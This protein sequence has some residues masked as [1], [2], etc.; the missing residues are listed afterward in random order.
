VSASAPASGTYAPAAPQPRN[1]LGIAALC[2]GLIGVLVGLIPA[3]FLGSGALGILGI[4]FGIIGIRR[5]KRG[6]A[7]NRGMAIIGLITGVIAAALA[8]WASS[9]SLPVSTSSTTTLAS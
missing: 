7:T 6:E 9:S 1:G 8:I 4:T 3:V 5:V 2:C